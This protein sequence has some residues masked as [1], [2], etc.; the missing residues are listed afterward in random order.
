MSK[1]SDYLNIFL[2]MGKLKITL[3]VPF[4]FCKHGKGA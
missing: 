2:W 3:N 4:V 1:P